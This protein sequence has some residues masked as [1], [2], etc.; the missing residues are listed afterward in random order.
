M[1]E[2]RSKDLLCFIKALNLRINAFI[3][4]LCPHADTGIPGCSR[5][6]MQQIAN[7]QLQCSSSETLIPVSESCTVFCNNG[8]VISGQATATCI[9]TAGGAA[10]DAIPTCNS[11]T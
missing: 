1:V 5:L 9:A 4:I 3:N 6:P 7:A 11:E 8:Y 10:F 2:P